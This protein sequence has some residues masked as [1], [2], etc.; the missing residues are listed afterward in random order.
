MKQNKAFTLA[1]LLVIIVII[2]LLI[3][4]TGVVMTRVMKGTKDNIKEQELKT[5]VD[6]AQSY[7]TDIVNDKN[8]YGFEDFNY[9][10]YDF[11]ENLVKKC[12]GGYRGNTCKYREA[13][14][15]GNYKIK[16]FINPSNLKD[17]VDMSKYIPGNC[18][19]D[20]YIDIST[21]KHGYYVLDKLE[22]KPGENTKAKTCVVTEE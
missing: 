5:L 20:A 9:S 19:L 15:D 4:L 18:G 7:M 10:G 17:Y 6:A 8:V 13:P 12:N 16:L 22:V 2:G 1:E 14:S 3:S 21:N 11:L